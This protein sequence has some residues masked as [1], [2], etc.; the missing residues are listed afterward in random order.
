MFHKTGTSSLHMSS[1]PALPQVLETEESSR[2]N[3]KEKS[4]INIREALLTFSVCLSLINALFIGSRIFHKRGFLA[5]FL[6]T[7]RKFSTE[8][9]S[10]PLVDRGGEVGGGGCRGSKGSAPR[11]KHN[12]YRWKL[13]CILYKG[14]MNSEFW[15]RSPLLKTY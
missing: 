5:D 3:H 6:N 2:T 15:V 8:D 10:V 9:N 12:S 14:L 13:M 7:K 4:N 11:P 1:W